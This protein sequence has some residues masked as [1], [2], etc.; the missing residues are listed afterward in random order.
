MER[1][2]GKGTMN[3][4]KNYE[5]VR[6]TN[7]ETRNEGPGSANQR[8]LHDPSSNINT[9]IRPPDHTLSVGARPPVLNYSIQ[10]GEEFSLEF[11]RERVIPRQHIVPNAY[12]DFNNPPVSMGLLGMLGISHTGPESG[13]DVTMLNTAETSH[14]Q[15]FGRKGSSAHEDRGYYDSVHS[16]SHTLSRNEVSQGVHGYT[17]S[18]GADCSSTKVKFLCSFGGKI[19]PRPIDGKL[20]YVGGETRIIRLSKDISWQELMQKALAIY[21]ET[22][23]LKYQLPGEDLDALVSVSCDEDLLNMMEEFNVLENRGQQKP[24]MFLFSSR[25]L[26][27][28]QFGLENM[29]VDSEIQYVVAVNGMDLGSRKSSIALA[30]TS[31]NNLDELLGL[32]VERETGRAAAEL[33]GASTTTLTLS[34]PASTIQSSQPGLVSSSSAYQLN[35]Q[36]YQGLKMH[37][38]E[39]SQHISSTLHS[40]E[41]FPLIDVKGSTLLSA[42]LQYDYGSNLA[43]HG[44]NS[45]PMP[46]YGQLDQPLAKELVHGGFRAEDQEV[47]L[48]EA[49]LKKVGSAPKINEPEK[50]SPLDKE[51]SIKDPK[52]K[53]DSLLAKINETEKIRISEKEHVVSSH[54]HTTVS[55]HI[56]R[57]EVSI[58]SSADI[59]SLPLPSKS[60]KKAQEPIQNPVPPEALNEGRKNN[61]DDCF[62]AIDGVFTSGYSD[63]EAGPTEFGYLEPSVIP[64]R[65]YHSERIPREQAEMSRLSKS[66]DSFGCQY[67]IPQAHGD[68]SQPIAES[69]DKLHESSMA[70]HTEQS[71]T[72]AKKLYTIPQSVEAELAQLRTP[73]VVADKMNKTNS[74][75]SEGMLESN[76]EKSEPRQVVPTSLVDHEV[77][78]IKDIYKEHTVSDKE[79]AGMKHPTASH[80]THSKHLKDSISKPSEYE[81]SDIT[82]KINNGNEREGHA[83]P[84][85]Q[86]ENPVRTGPLRD[87]SVGVGHSEQGDILIDINDRFPH[88]FLTDMFSKARISENLAGMS[89]MH[90]DGP[91]A[92]WNVENRDPKRWSYFRNLAQDEFSRK[93]VS[94]MDQDHPGLAHPLT[95]IKEGTPADYS[96]PPLQPDGSAMTQ[97]EL[98]INVGEDIQRESSSTVRPNTMDMRQDNMH[99][100]L[101]GDQSVHLQ[102]MNGRIPESEYEEGRLDLPS[103]S[104]H[105]VDL[106][107]GDFDISTLQII[108]NEDLE[109]LIELGSGTFGTVYHGKW[110][111]T[112]VAIKRIKKSCFTG[113]S[114]EQERLTVEFWREA[115]I[116]SK[117]HHPNVVAFYGVVQDGPGGTLATVAEFMVNGSLRHVLLSKDRQLDRRKRLIIAMDAAFGMEYLHSKNIVHFDLKCDNLLVNLKDPLRPI[118]KVGDF[119]LSKI[120]RNTLVTGGVRGT[121]PWMAPELLN[122]SSS[123]VSEKVDVFSFGIVLWEILTGE[124]PY[125]NMHY[126]A[127]IGGIVNNTLRPLV[128]SS[129]DYE[130]RLLMEQCWAPDPVARP[131]FT[132]IARRLRVMSAAC[133]TKSHAQNQVA[134]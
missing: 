70:S 107:L 121:L 128:P 101:Q 9:N 100:H 62:Y 68:C 71:V 26:E 13:S 22:H 17:S 113:R 112:D 72:S 27:D 14:G 20:R 5:Q 29:E 35:S 109:E 42:P 40:T 65:V 93:D 108:K 63:V 69:V 123:K 87:S 34:V 81:W 60:N 12:G 119:G 23:T 74:N 76:L 131:S 114:S 82:E 21:S 127:I 130:W 64:Q 122:G 16:V 11:M 45:G 38:G 116:L 134:K 73:K 37:H 89:P 125:A 124:E 56:P 52:T 53:R 6:Y 39:A 46:L 28:A 83:Q 49:K 1:N 102:G 105:F 47:F 99:S 57:E 80:G 133:Q 132:E 120:K 86:I 115:E 30:S 15:E 94:L 3:Q 96:Y 117:L 4:A 92:S 33:A 36:P 88:D 48:K 32:N 18:G 61:D 51:A 95:N 58:D 106:G 111:G 129:C 54:P 44:E 79:A 103:T 118:C 90:G 67:L 41:S 10:T 2:F 25:D 50:I 77:T 91:V 8:F 85:A 104:A 24:R 7:V 75:I 59:G 126:G 66:D 55:G 97:N 19:L 43:I 110:R 98:H 31:Q 78:R 84:F